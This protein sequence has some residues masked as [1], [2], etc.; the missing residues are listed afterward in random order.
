MICNVLPSHA[1]PAPAPLVLSDGWQ[2]QDAAK[3]SASGDQISTA[4]FAA[5]GWYRA[6]VPGTVLTSLV[7]NRVYPEPLY[8]ENSRPE[9]IPESLARTAW[10]YRT[11]VEVPKSYK[12]RV[13]WLNF[14]GINYSSEVWVNGQKVGTTRGAFI[15]GI[16][17]VSKLVAPGHKAAIAVLVHP[18]PTPGTPH[19]HTL[20]AGVGQNGGDSALDG[21]TFLSTIGWDWLNAVRDRATGIWQ[22]VSLSASGP[23]IVK[24]PLVTTDL[25]LPR[26]DSSDVAVEATVENVSGH[27]VKGVLHGTIEQISFEKAVELAPHS[28]QRIRFDAK[29]TPALHMEHPRLWWPNGYGA[30]ELYTLHLV[31]NAGQEESDATDVSFGVRKIEYSVPGVDTL[32]IS[33]NGVKI[34]IRGGN[35]GLDEAMKRIPRERLDAEIRMHR[36]A[37]LNLIRNWVGQSTSEDFYSLCDKYGILVWDEFFQPNPGDGPNPTDLDTYMA[38]VRD[39]ILRFRNHPSIMLWCARNE[40]FPPPAIDAALRK[41]MAELEPTRRYQPSSTDGAGV[42]S[43]GPYYW[44]EPRAYY[45]IT[46]DYFKTETGSMSVPTLESIHGM[47]PEKDWNTIN[48]DWAAH[49]MAKGAQHGDTYPLE[50]AARYGKVANLSDFVRKAQMMNFESYRA[51][52][53]GRNA[54]LFNPTTA[55]ITWMSHPAQPSFVW[56]LYHYDLEPSAALFGARAANERVHVQLNEETGEVMVIN[57]LPTELV[58]ASVRARIYNLDGS[59]GLE[60]TKPVTAAA[61][62]A[63]SLGMITATATK[64]SPVYIVRLELLD[65]EGKLLSENVYWKSSTDKV[66]DLTALDSMPQVRLAGKVAQQD[67]AGRRTVTVTLTNG[68]ATVALMTHLQLRRAQSR[69][70]VLPV[71]YGDNYITLAPGESRTVTMEAAAESFKGEDALV[72][73]DGWNVTVAADDVR[74]GARMAPNEDAD[75]RKQPQTGLPFQTTGLR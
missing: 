66:D 24:A 11:V 13:L 18:Q 73:V 53:E 51:M 29:S 36:Q 49:D 32:T 17:D 20:R 58:H 2:L 56:Q 71:F 43:H 61:S 75:P 40:G 39:K 35:W 23:V 21:P 68:S 72:L 62:R 25:P 14:N 70:R 28:T 64:L 50:L 7:N 42:R 27:A 69:E 41:L 45:K 15:R 16:F 74:K 31:F 57:N 26:T 48:D 44:R 46:D 4:E 3:V 6:T 5:T 55:L 34:F 47:M 10:W 9:I 65:A 59:L 54:K 19:E 30:P 67:N 22:K 33:V 52:Y 60:Q 12:G 1:S 63:S 8:G 38:N 37:N